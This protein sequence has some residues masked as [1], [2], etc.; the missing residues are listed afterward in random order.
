MYEILNESCEK[1]NEILCG[2]TNPPLWVTTPK[3]KTYPTPDNEI[4]GP[5]PNS[6]PSLF[7]MPAIAVILGN[8]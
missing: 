3:A 7:L 1:A 8:K 4:L 5:N 2:I 6:Y